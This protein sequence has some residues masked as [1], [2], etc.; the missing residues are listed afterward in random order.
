[1]QNK[2][3]NMKKTNMQAIPNKKRIWKKKYEENPEPKREFKKKKKKK[4]VENTEPKI[5]YE[6]K[7]YQ[8]NP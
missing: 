6:I 4:I 5:L 3:E 7:K 2:K 8:E 1:M